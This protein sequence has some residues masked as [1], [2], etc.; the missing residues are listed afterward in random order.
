M[1][2]LSLA[3]LITH[4]IFAM[5]LVRLSRQ[6]WLN[7]ALLLRGISIKINRGFKHRISLSNRGCVFTVAE[8]IS[9]Q[10]HGQDVWR[11]TLTY[12]NEQ[13]IITTK[14]LAFY[15]GKDRRTGKLKLD[16]DDLIRNIHDAIIDW[17]RGS[18]WKLKCLDDDAPE[19]PPKRKRPDKQY[20]II[21]L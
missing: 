20:E 7:N 16:K 18:R 3:V 19:T 12:K 11:I 5:I 17:G 9:R 21:S 4:I 8:W 6:L 1:P 2:I 15:Y 14:T 13:R 10:D